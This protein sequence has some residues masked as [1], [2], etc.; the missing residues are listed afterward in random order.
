LKQDVAVSRQNGCLRVAVWVA[1]GEMGLYQRVAK[2]WEIP[3]LWDLVRS[4]RI[5][6]E[7]EAAQVGG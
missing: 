5:Y 7:Q 1:S 2:H 3:E 4:C 6:H